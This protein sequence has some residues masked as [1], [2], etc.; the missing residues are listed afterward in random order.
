M[1][2]RSYFKKNFEVGGIFQKERMMEAKYQKWILKL[3]M[4]ENTIY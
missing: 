2:I 3:N 1:K 4:R